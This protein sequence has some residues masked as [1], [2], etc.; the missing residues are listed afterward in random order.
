MSVD[1]EEPKMN[2]S[3]EGSEG[4]GDD[5]RPEAY[6]SSE[7]EEDDDEEEIQKIREGF[8]VDDED[9]E[10]STQKRRKKH[11][12]RHQEKEIK[13]QD[14]GLLDEDDLDLLMENTGT[15]RDKSTSKFKRLKKATPEEQPERL[16]DLNDFFSEDEDIG[17]EDEPSTSRK[18]DTNRV[19]DEFDDFIEDDEF[20]DMDED[21][22]A[23]ARERRQQE[24]LKPLEITGIDSE[25]IDELY[26][27]FG[28]GEDYAWALE[29]EE[30]EGEFKED[31][32]RPQLQDIYEPEEL[33]ARMLTDNDKVIRDTDIPERFQMLRKG[34]KN[35]ELE[36]ADFEYEKE[37]IAHRLKIETLY[38]SNDTVDEEAFK[39]AVG[40]VLTFVTKN[41]LEVPFIYSHRRDHLLK[42]TITGEGDHAETVVVS[43][44][45]ENDLWRIV[46]M[47][48]EFHA[49]IEKRDQMNILI[50][51][52]ELN[53]EAVSEA[54]GEARSVTDLQD[55]HDYI[56]F[57]YSAQLKDL[58]LKKSHHKSNIY[59]KIRKDNLYEIIKSI[60]ITSSEYA[61]NITAET[62]FFNTKD[63]EKTPTELAETICSEPD[64]LFLKA[65]QALEVTKR[66]FA[67][68]LFTNLKVRRY[69]RNLMS[70][71]STINIEL[72]EQGRL[73]I[74]K[75]SPYADFKYAI[76]RTHDSMYSQP[77]LFLRMLEAES[78]NLVK[79]NLTIP[80]QSG[81]FES[82]FNLLASDGQSD[83]ANEWNNYRRSALEIAFKKLI[84]LVA[85][86]V[87]EDIRR[88]CERLLF[89]EIRGVFLKKIDCAP[90]H[91][92]GTEIGT[93]PKVFALTP[94]NGKFGSDAVVAAC[95]D[96]FGKVVQ[97]F[98]FNE[99]PRISPDRLRAGETAFEAVFVEAI[100]ET[101]PDVIAING[102]NVNT[103]KLY[104]IIQGIISSY[105]L[106]SG[107]TQH[108]LEIIY[109]NDEV[110]MRYQ[111]SPRSTAE[112]PD[113]PTLVRY[114]IGLA[115]YVQSPLLE[116]L[117][118]G[119]EVTALSIH[120]HQ[121]LL[122]EERFK[123]ALDTAFV[124]I[125][126]MVG[127]DIN[128][129]VSDSYLAS[130]LP[131][132]AGLGDRKAFGLLRAVQQNPLFS[133]QALITNENIRIGTTI[134]LNCASFLRIPQSKSRALRSEDEVEAV[135]VLDETRIHPEDYALAE[136]M[137]ADALD[138]DEDQIEELK[139]AP[140]GETIIDR[141]MNAPEGTSLLQSLVLED[142]SRQL[143]ETYHKKKRATLQMISEELQDP[144]AEIRGSFKL[145][146]SEQV[147]ESL[148][149]ESASSLH[150][151]VVIPMLVMR[152]ND[153]RVTGMTP[154]SIDLSAN[155]D[156]ARAPRDRRRLAEIYQQGQTI[157]ASIQT[158]D[159]ENFTAEV[160]LLD[161]D[162]KSSIEQLKFDKSPQIW[163]VVKE[164]A[165]DNIEK[166]KQEVAQKG[167]R[168]I[169]HPL[170]HNFNSDQ[171]QNF[172]A[173]K[174]RGAAV[175]R[176][177]SKGFDH[178]A[179]T[180]KVDNNL[181]QHID[182]VEHGKE[183]D[184]S[185]GKYL[186]I[187][188]HRYTDLDEILETYVGEIVK[189]INE[190]VDNDKFR[191]GTK[192]EVVEWIENYSK[193]NPKRGVYAFAFN[194][195]RPGW[196]LLLFKTGPQSQIYTW[197]VKAVPEGY[198]LNTY[199]YPNVQALCNGFKT[200]LKNRSTQPSHY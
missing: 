38:G 107:E 199:P 6:D 145:M 26:D 22:R 112:F 135:T 191:S 91:A 59:D 152:V 118:L 178:I 162:V 124:D 171:A 143:E 35:Y 3:D 94:G 137:A 7:E 60:G 57:K 65:S 86:N 189:R 154:S 8:I 194:H 179:I 190:M 98:K 200:L 102:F 141:L 193:A 156:F 50:S 125:V 78:M 146:T 28:D 110:A 172:L 63:S 92:P 51:K 87:K 71:L 134:F 2:L 9:D 159:Y 34:I 169:K 40:D 67:E 148:T 33:K 54:V 170:F 70:E 58:G 17:M 48:I 84:P 185:I 13:E 99:N 175:I 104:K 1:D 23:A 119:D 161:R 176:P 123:N 157:P 196:F 127:V 66:F 129:C 45:G 90:F 149:G 4:E 93:V 52:L 56:S 42:T 158:I 177:S 132:I 39:R 197:N 32:A 27:I 165:D 21:A 64:S 81:L 95:L 121:S 168:V 37:W 174:L 113:K 47:D 88:E 130:S 192:D 198:E 163:D 31:E 76:N 187:D 164:E 14:D 138:L 25:K 188:K 69:F 160:S 74:D 89:F 105:G 77:D 49:L 106:K 151:G 53:D 183:N 139:D 101:Q 153:Y 79:I 131:F 19:M 16:K 186:T 181:Y 108:S 180:W 116:Y 140:V 41:N 173:P 111:N 55:I 96:K 103:S 167:T 83:L 5:L 150:R 126:N 46:Q 80:G 184:Y 122:P 97:T 195:K 133:R 109:A 136:K 10:V 115:R 147:F 11:K 44:L 68:E 15:A 36:D 100:R 82:V 24:R 73:K 61:E 30:E 12:R 117:N 43:L 72:T 62:R 128:K 144:Y 18:R 120:K 29:G 75:N 20:S 114:A 182:V 85:L 155:A 142:Y 166:R